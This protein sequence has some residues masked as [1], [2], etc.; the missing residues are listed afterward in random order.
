MY[1]TNEKTYEVWEISGVDDY[2]QP[3]LPAATGAKVIANIVDKQQTI[4]EDQVEYVYSTHFGLTLSK[5]L[6]VGQQLR[7]AADHYTIKEVNN[8]GRLTQLVLQRD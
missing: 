5:N 1:K 6:V 3:G 2:G 7:H 8:S 4:V